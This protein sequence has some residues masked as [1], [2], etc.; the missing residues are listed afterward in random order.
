[1]KAPLDSTFGHNA[2]GP[3]TDD[4]FPDDERELQSCY[5]GF[6]QEEEDGYILIEEISSDDDY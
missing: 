5:T 3:L 1:M 4:F 2:L 6:H